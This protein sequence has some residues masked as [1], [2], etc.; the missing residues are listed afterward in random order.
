MS[1]SDQEVVEEV[2]LTARVIERRSYK[3]WFAEQMVALEVPVALFERLI[4]LARLGAA[5]SGR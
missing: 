4:E 2:E 1:M 3:G 5:S